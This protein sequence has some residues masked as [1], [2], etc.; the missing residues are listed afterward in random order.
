VFAAAVGGPTLGAIAIVSGRR[1]A[2]EARAQTT[3]LS[4]REHAHERDLRRVERIYEDKKAAYLAI[5]KWV[6]IA[7]QR[8]QATEPIISF[9]GDPQPPE[10][11]SEDAWRELQVS[12][13]AFGTQAVHDALDDFIVKSRTFH[14]NVSTY[15]SVRDQGGPGTGLADAA[16][17]M[18]DARQ[19][20][21]AA[22][23]T[24]C[25]LIRDELASM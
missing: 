6:L 2:R 4:D 5:L 13:N 24:V 11:P 10:A 7:M 14:L 17:Q 25:D 1:E 16:Q 3:E 19:A 15:R 8:I 20:A 9:S 18:N 12:A 23:D 21:G 22:Y